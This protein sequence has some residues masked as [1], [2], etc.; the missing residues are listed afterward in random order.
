M[1]GVTGLDLQALGRA[2]HMLLGECGEH[3]MTCMDHLWKGRPGIGGGVV[4]SGMPCLC[5]GKHGSA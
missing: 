5:V 1:L 4:R 3:S 2:P